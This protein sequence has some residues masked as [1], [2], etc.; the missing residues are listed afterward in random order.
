LTLDEG[1]SR[2]IGRLYEAV[3]DPDAWRHVMDELMRRTESRLAFVSY[4]DVRHCEFS[5]TEFYGSDSSA[6]ARGIKE[7]GAE[8]FRLDPSLLWASKRPDA[9]VCDTSR[10]MA[11]EDFRQNEYVKWQE[12]RFGTVH[13]RVFYTQPVDDLSFALSLHPPASEGPAGREK[14]LLH[15]L[16]FEHMERALRLAARPP[17]LAANAE[18][19]VI[20]D[21]VGHA[22]AMSARAEELVQAGD[23]LNLDR[24]RLS[25]PL[26]DITARLNCAIASAVKSGSLGGAGGGVRVPRL[27]GR[28]DWLVLVSPCPRHLEH[29]PVRTPAALLRIIETDPAMTLGRAEAALFDLTAR[30]IDVAHA[31]LRG[32]SLESLGHALGISRNTVK[33]HLQ[34]L[35]R[36]T[37]T[38]RQS[39]LVHL[40]T[41]VARR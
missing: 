13:W 39:E 4:A 31:L 5:R 16:L 12:S 40:L 14:G 3:F 17:D 23:G 6:F 18:A 29:L 8:M 2:F 26:L 20:L 21:T 30:E 1:V 15:K 7:Y 27:S 10:I 37:G 35:F 19:I 22:M 24:R 41:D 32:H 34:S 11:H 38:S 25:S 36:K 33:V 28:P 9:G